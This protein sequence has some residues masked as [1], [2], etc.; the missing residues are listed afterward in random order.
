ML[1][2]SKDI[3]REKIIEVAAELFAKFGYKKTS[4]ED[5]ANAMHKTKTSI[6]YY[7]KNKESVFEAVI[8]KE[9]DLLTQT[10]FL[11]LQQ[12]TTPQE[13]LRA[14]IHSRMEA[15]NKVSL[16]YNSMKSELLDHLSF[17]DKIREE[18]LLEE[19]NLVKSILQDGVEKGIFDIKN[20]D[21]TSITIV[22]AL[23]GL[24]IPLFLRI[25]T[26]DTFE[27]IDN[28]IDIICNG[29]LKRK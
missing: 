26:S 15:L 22:T 12:T 29:L 18:Y 16:L 20:L 14:Y 28:L 9:A 25:D 10:I 21:L 23:K 24:E 17:M 7:F 5:I 19:V 27:K 1:E 2:N 6:Y 4:L 11:A 3:Q 8:K 13:M